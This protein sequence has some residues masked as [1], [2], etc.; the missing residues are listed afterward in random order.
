MST[1]RAG[2]LALAVLA[3]VSFFG[4][5]KA[6]P[7]ANPYEL[8]AVFDNVTNLKPRSPVRIAGVEIGKV[9]KVKPIT[10]EEGAAEVTMELKDK[11]LPI[12][13]DAQLKIRS[14]IFL[15]GNFFIDIRPG[16][17]SAPEL[18]DGSVIPIQ[19]TATPVQFGELISTLQHDTREDLQSFLRE[20]SKGLSGK[21]A[22]GFNE[23]I[24]YW[25]GAY[26]GSAL[27]NDATLGQDP[28]RDIQRMLRGQART[29]RALSRDEETLK[30]LVTDFNT[31]AAA[32]AAEDAALERSVP[33]LRDV[34]VRGQPALA[35]LDA[36][37]P[38]LRAFARDALPGVRSSRPTLDLAIPFIRQARKLVSPAELRGAARE[39]RRA[40]PHLVRLNQRNVPFLAQARALSACTNNVLVP[41]V[42]DRIPDPDFP[43]NS[44]QTVN[45]QIQR[46][47][48]GLAG[49]SRLRDANSSLFNTQGVP[50]P[51]L[52]KVRPA[53][54]ADGGVTPPSHRPDVPCETQELP[55]LNA[56]GGAIDDP[57]VSS[58]PGPV[59]DALPPSRPDPAARAR[60]RRLIERARAAD[61]RSARR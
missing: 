46:G 44:E 57:S 54:P 52:T 43:E 49:E 25:Q 61:K 39:L 28:D 16:S 5:T 45:Q 36:A 51:K 47:L 35:S 37:L 23:S 3:V 12:H 11:A 50:P 10:E 27:A 15:E 41:F 31:T 55:D 30:D 13:E 14:R 4:F 21:G 33:A 60:L 22:K 18:P 7:F 29:F 56:P 20:Y 26:R 38:T 53:R 19:Q 24:R 6:N 17:P 2:I 1:L 40:V 48:V 59:L 34:V 9:V 42:S 32:F 8:R 58:L